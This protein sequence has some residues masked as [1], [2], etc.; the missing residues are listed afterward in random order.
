M[1]YAITLA[2]DQDADVNVV[3]ASCARAAVMCKEKE[4]VPQR[5]QMRRRVTCSLLQ[6]SEDSTK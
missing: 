2:A 4:V 5:R 1:L 6:A 3:L